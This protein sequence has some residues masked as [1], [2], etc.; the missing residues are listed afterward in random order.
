M[1]DE[2]GHTD[3]AGERDE[4]NQFRKPKT[5][6][7]LKAPTQKEMEGHAPLHVKYQNW[8]PLCVAAEGCHDYC[9]SAT[10]EEND[11]K[12]I[13]IS[14]GYCFL[15]REDEPDTTPKVLIMHDDGLDAP[16]ALLVKKKGAVHEVVQWVLQK[17]EESA[18]AGQHISLKTDQDEPIMALTR[19]IIA[20]RAARTTPIES[21]ARVSK[22]NPLFERAVRRWRGQ[23]RKV[24]LELE[25][26]IGSR[27]EVDHPA[28]GWMVSWAGDMIFKYRERANGRTAYEDMSGHTV[29]HSVA[30]FGEEVLFQVAKDEGHRNK[31]DGE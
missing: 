14:L 10:E 18:R 11:G 25:K 3:Q 31:F 12:G 21:K 5:A 2:V 24:K 28:V 9:R 29:R 6:K 8:C 27:V 13:T 7:I 4:P 1:E 15:T 23:F 30:G 22:S 17:I 26:N 20:R 19:S 16:W